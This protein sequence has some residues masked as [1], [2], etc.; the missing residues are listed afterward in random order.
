MLPQHVDLLAFNLLMLVP[1]LVRRNMG[2]T[3]AVACQRIWQWRRA[4]AQDNGALVF[5]LPAYGDPKTA[6]PTREWYED[7]MGADSWDAVPEN[8]RDLVAVFGLS[9]SAAG[10]FRETAVEMIRALVTAC[11]DAEAAANE[12][13]DA[14]LE[15]AQMAA[16]GDS[17]DSDSVVSVAVTTRVARPPPTIALARACAKDRKRMWA[18]GWP[19][20]QGQARN[21]A[22]RNL[23]MTPPP[24][25]N[26]S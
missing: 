12:A 6:T 3:A 7:I 8:T 19:D 17:S 4:Y 14:A 21:R 22:I 24:L 23:L 15:A 9:S 20:T 13:A 10:S 5:T 2:R 11:A 1:T 26:W 18:I 16:G 25:V